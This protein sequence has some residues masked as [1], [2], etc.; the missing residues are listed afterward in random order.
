M[1]SNYPDWLQRNTEALRNQSTLTAK[2]LNE[3]LIQFGI[4]GKSAEWIKNVFTPKHQ[5]YDDAVVAW[6]D[7]SERTT[8]KKTALNDAKADFMATYREL[9]KFLKT[10]PNVSN[11]DLVKMGLP[12]RSNNKPTPSPVP[13]TYPDLIA[14]PD[15]PRSIKVS[16]RDHSPTLSAARPHGV[17]GAV[18]KWAV[19]PEPPKSVKELINSALDTRSPHVFSFDESERGRVLYVAAAWQSTRGEMGKYSEIVSTFIP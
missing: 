2:Y 13:A 15:G 8:A 14:E 3:H 1:S 10:N 9:Y 18:L 4:S 16:F 11:E 6:L 17:G 5:I 12:A 7:P 19:L